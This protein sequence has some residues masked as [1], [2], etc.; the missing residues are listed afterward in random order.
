MRSLVISYYCAIGFF[1]F[2][3]N[4]TSLVVLG[5]GTFVNIEK[6]MDIKGFEPLTFSMQSRRSTTDLNALF[7]GEK[8][9]C[10]YSVIT[11]F[12][13]M[14]WKSNTHKSLIWRDYRRNSGSFH[15]LSQYSY[16]EA[17]SIFDIK[18]NSESSC[19]GNRLLE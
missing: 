4:P 11:Y 6:S 16:I 3:S 7:L 14:E 1:G 18:D 15:D 2:L 17:V 19:Q 5:H 13:D 12:A 10:N 9:I 8:M